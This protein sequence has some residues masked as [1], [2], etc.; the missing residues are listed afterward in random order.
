MHIDKLWID[1][2]RGLKNAEI[3]FHPGLNVLVGE[4]NAGKT[5][6]LMAL[7]LVLSAS[8]EVDR[9]FL[10]VDDLHMGEDGPVDTIQVECTIGGLSWVQP[11]LRHVEC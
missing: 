7:R 2:L 4:N 3:R 5:T 10:S 6:I 8:D 9:P 1:G 11:G